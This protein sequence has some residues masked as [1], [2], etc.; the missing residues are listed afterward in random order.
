M[1]NNDF[2]VYV[3]YKDGKPWREGN[4]IGVYMTKR[5]SNQVVSREAKYDVYGICRKDEK[6]YF[7]LTDEERCMYV[8]KAKEHYEVKEFA[9]SINKN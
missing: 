9:E 4:K 6:H 5:S 3:I 7:E 1:N 2:K 8:N